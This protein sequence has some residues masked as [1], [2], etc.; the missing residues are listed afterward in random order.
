[1][2]EDRARALLAS[3]LSEMGDI[4]LPH[5]VLDQVARHNR[6]LFELAAN[7]LDS[8]MDDTQARQVLDQ[9]MESYKDELV[10]TIMALRGGDEGDG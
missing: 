1:M 6:H 8:G 5:Q 10:R 2:S 3:A 7:L 9:A 4:R